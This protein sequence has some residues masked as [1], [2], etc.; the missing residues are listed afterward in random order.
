MSEA[1]GPDASRTTDLPIKSSRGMRRD[2]A[3]RPENPDAVA[4]IDSGCQWADRRPE[5]ALF[6]TVLRRS[7][8]DQDG[9]LER[10]QAGTSRKRG[11]PAGSRG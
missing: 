6:R 8:G 10:E 11:R 1:I 5:P 2:S 3:S 7:T 4:V 9:R